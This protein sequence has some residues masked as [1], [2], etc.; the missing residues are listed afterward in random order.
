MLMGE[1]DYIAMAYKKKLAM[2][3][4]LNDVRYFKSTTVYEVYVQ[5]RVYEYHYH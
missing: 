5:L 1:L 3:L 2:R 4:Q